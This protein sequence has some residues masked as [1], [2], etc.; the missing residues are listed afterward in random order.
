MLFYFVR[1]AAGAMALGVPHALCFLK[2][3][4]FTHDS[5]AICAAR[6]WTHVSDVIARSQRVA[7][8]ARAF[9]T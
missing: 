6:S 8:T 1:E 7:M 5:G 9:S 4:W 2:G 3:K